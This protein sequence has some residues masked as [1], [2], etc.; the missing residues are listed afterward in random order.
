MLRWV[1]ELEGAGNSKLKIQLCCRAWAILVVI[2][3]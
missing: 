3:F 2:G 1:G